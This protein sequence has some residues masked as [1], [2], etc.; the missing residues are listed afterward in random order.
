MRRTLALAVFAAVM[1]AN[2]TATAAAPSPVPD[3]NLH[4]TLTHRYTVAQLRRG[5]STM[6]AYVKEYTDCYDVIQRALLG[7]IRPSG[8]SGGGGGGDSFLPTPVIVVLVLL[9]L[10]AAGLGAVALRR[11]GGGSPPGA[12]AP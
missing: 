8:P 7:G 1:A 5:L 11:R 12:S 10:A 9:A 6:P 2:P 3:C 4:S